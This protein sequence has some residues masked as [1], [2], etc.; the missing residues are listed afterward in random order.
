MGEF[1]II[2]DEKKP[3][4]LVDDDEEDNES[5]DLSDVK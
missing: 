3:I 4:M 2:C 1:K 5:I